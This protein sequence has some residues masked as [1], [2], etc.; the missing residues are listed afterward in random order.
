MLDFHAISIFY[1]VFD[2]FSVWGSKDEDFCQTCHDPTKNK[3]A[4]CQKADF[5]RII[6]Q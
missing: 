1:P 5:L 2:T 6:A 4:Y 3:V